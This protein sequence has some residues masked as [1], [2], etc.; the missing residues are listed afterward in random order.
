MIFV[1]IIII[2]Y[3]YY[4]WVLALLVVNILFWREKLVFFL[5]DEVDYGFLL[6]CKSNSSSQVLV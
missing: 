2:I 4:A 3:H 5:I 1:I 6:T